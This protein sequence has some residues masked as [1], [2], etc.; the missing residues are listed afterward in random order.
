MSKSKLQSVL[1]SMDKS[2]IIKMVLELDSARKEAKEYL[3]FYAEPVSYT[4]LMDMDY[5]YNIYM[6]IKDTCSSDKLERLRKIMEYNS[7]LLYTS[8][9]GLPRKTVVPPAAWTNQLSVHGEA[10]NAPF[11]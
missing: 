8:P 5:T 11:M 6:D 7:C 3:D 9:S 10:T 1:M 4:H 2:E